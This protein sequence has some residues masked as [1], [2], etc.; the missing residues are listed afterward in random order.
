MI[1]PACGSNN[2]EDAK[3]CKRCGKE[4]S[5]SQE[6]KDNIDEPINSFN[7]EF[8]YNNQTN[9]NSTGI[10]K[11]EVDNS[12]GAQ[13]PD[14]PELGLGF[15]DEEDIKEVQKKKKNKRTPLSSIIIFASSLVATI[16]IIFLLLLIF[17]GRKEYIHAYVCSTYYENMPPKELKFDKNFELRKDNTFSLRVDDS[18]YVDG[19]Y[20]LVEETTD[21]KN[22]RYTVNLKASKRML[23]GVEKN[24]DYDEQYNLTFMGDDIYLE[25]TTSGIRYLCKITE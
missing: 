24:D 12:G 5:T 8:I 15:D 20:E 16:T 22:D 9:F 23:G 21:G 3:E 13:V 11:S 4:I 25:S 19:N 7:N 10:N 18:N 14:D 2:A 17:L 6:E 1:C